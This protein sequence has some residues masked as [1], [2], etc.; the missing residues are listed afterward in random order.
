MKVQEG[1][2]DFV[3]TEVHMYSISL[4]GEHVDTP[5]ILAEYAEAYGVGPGWTFLTGDYDDIDLLRHRLGIYDP[6]PETGKTTPEPSPN[7][8]AGVLNDIPGT[9]GANV[10]IRQMQ[11]ASG[12]GP[13]GEHLYTSGGHLDSTWFNRTFWQAGSAM[14][15][16]LMR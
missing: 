7:K 15:S 12:D 11:V 13:A 6:D 4:D 16:G 14:T 10:F 8:M 1:L 5:E 3:G 9:D 2:G